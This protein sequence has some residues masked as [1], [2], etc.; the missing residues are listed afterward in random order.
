MTIAA[1][2]TA[3]FT[4]TAPVSQVPPDHSAV[5]AAP[6]PRTDAA[7]SPHIAR[8]HGYAQIQTGHGVGSSPALDREHRRLVAYLRHQI[9]NK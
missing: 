9:R 7:P 5:A 1:I 8:K 2:L 4:S 3:L 6:Q